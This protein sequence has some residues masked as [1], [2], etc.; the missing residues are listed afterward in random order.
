MERLLISLLLSYLLGS[1]P[2][3]L[4]VG[5]LAK[6]VDL[7]TVGSGNVGGNNLIANAGPLW[8]LLGG[9]LDAAKGAAAMWLAGILGVSYPISFLSGLFV[10]VGHN[11]SLWM[12]FR[13]GKGLATAFGALAWLA[14][15]EALAGAVVWALINWRA[16]GTT[17]TIAAFVSLGVLFYISA[18]PVEYSL[19]ALGI[20]SLVFVASFRDLVQQGKAAGHWSEIFRSPK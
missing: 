14:W 1:I 18:R 11:W 16:G 12:G 20:V 10:V 8:G 9:G 17:A 15:P 7:R 13:G 6:G 2:F 5:R 19:L 3:S 4:I